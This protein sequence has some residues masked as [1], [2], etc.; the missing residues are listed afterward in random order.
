MAS[1]EVVESIAPPRDLHLRT[2]PNWT[3]V[4][5]FAVLSAL[6]IGVAAP[7][8]IHGRW[9][10]YLSLVLAVAF[11][12]VAL[13][14]YAARFEL[15]I[16]AAERRIRLRHT[17]GPIRFERSVSFDEV[18]AVRLTLSRGRRRVESRIEVLCDNEDI[19][20]PPTHIPRQQA[21][22]LAVTTGVELIKVTHD[23]QPDRSGREQ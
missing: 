21:L 18:H 15:C 7:A 22:F 10:G 20:C 4:A 12:V 13:A 5:F 11:A 16:L 8:F 6:H 1:R 3:I 17:L 23:Q 9:E 19:E 14:G 2:S